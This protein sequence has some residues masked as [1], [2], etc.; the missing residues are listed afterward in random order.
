VIVPQEIQ[1]NR[2]TQEREASS[3]A[4]PPPSSVSGV[5]NPALQTSQQ[6]LFTKFEK[7]DKQ[8]NVLA[9]FSFS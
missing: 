4:A 5:I 7:F 3:P 1:S 6:P 9:N 8:L 2:K